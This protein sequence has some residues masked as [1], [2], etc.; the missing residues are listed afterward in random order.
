MTQTSRIIAPKIVTS[1]MVKAA[2]AYNNNPLTG[3]IDNAL[4]PANWVKGLYDAMMAAAPEPDIKHDMVLALAW[5]ASMPVSHIME[6]IH[7]EQMHDFIL[8]AVEGRIQ[9]T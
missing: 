8:N 7:L 9:L 3:G 6:S 5:E 4:E 1:A 2:L